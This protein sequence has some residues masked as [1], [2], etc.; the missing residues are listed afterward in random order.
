MPSPIRLSLDTAGKLVLSDG[1]TTEVKSN[2]SDLKVKWKIQDDAK[3][4]SFRI[5]GKIAYNPFYEDIPNVYDTKLKLEVRSGHSVIDWEYFIFWKDSYNITHKYDP[6]IAIK[7]S[8]TLNF[9]K[10]ILGG[11][12]LGILVLFTREFMQKKR[13]RR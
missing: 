1:G 10:P 11:L 8:F 5:E 2:S 13:N 7:P 3:I 4:T 9:L 6:K 12:I